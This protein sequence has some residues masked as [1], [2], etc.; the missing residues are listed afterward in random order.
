MPKVRANKRYLSPNK[1]LDRKIIVQKK[2]TK[3]K[4]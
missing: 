2:N 4:R 1:G 3:K